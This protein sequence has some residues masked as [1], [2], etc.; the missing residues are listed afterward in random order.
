MACTDFLFCLIEMKESLRAF[1]NF[2][3]DDTFLAFWRR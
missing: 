1:P 2:L 3:L